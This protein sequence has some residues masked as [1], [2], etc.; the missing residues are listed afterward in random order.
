MYVTVPVVH[1]TI[2]LRYQL[3]KCDVVVHVIDTS[4]GGKVLRQLLRIYNTEQLGGYPGALLEG[5]YHHAAR[6]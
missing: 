3:G 6:V 4:T 1:G 5:V 2:T